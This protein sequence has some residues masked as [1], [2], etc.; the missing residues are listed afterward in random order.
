M[1]KI[2]TSLLL[3]SAS[4]SADYDNFSGKLEIE[5]ISELRAYYKKQMDMCMSISSDC[6]DTDPLMSWYYSGQTTAYGDAIFWIDM[7]G[8]P[9][10][11]D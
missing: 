4:L 8:R 5:N 10:P 9:V 11:C 1:K 3:L 2:L 6:Y 7:I